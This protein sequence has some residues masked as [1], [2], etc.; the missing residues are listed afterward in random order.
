M[1]NKKKVLSSL[2]MLGSV[3][4]LTNCTKNLDQLPVSTATKDAIFG[5]E[6]GLKTYS[7]SFYDMLP[8]MG[9]IFRTDGNIS[10]YGATNQIPNYLTSNGYTADNATG[11]NWSD[12]R[13]VNYFIENCNYPT[14]SQSVREN[15]IGLARFFRAYFYYNKVKQ[16]GD[17]PWYSTSIGV[18]DSAAL[19]KKRD[20]RT[21]VMDSVVADLQYAAQHITTS[22][23]DTRSTVTQTVVLGYL[24]RIALYEG[25][26][27]KYHPEFKLQGSANAML[28]IAADAAQSIITSGTFRLNTGD[29]T[30]YRKLFTSDAPV[31]SEIML[32]NITSASL[33][34]YNDANWYF[35]SSTYGSRFSFIKKFMNTYL[36]IDGSSF[37]DK[38]GYDTIPYIRE[39]QN[40]DWRLQQTIRGTNYKVTTNGGNPTFAA[41][42]FSY[43]YTGYQPI[44]WVLDD[45]KYNNNSLNTNAISLLR[46]AEVLLNYAEAKAELGTLTATDWAQTIGALRSRAGIVNGISALPTQVDSYLQANY[47]PD[48][49]NPVILEIRR[50]RGIELALEGFRFDDLVRWKEGQNLTNTW[51]GMYVPNVGEIMDL[52]GDGKGDV[53]FYL[54]APTAKQPGVTYIDVSTASMALDHK[55]YG[56]LI[57]LGNTQKSWNDYKYLYPIPTTVL[58]K[59]S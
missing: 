31:A 11:W 19:F 30:S 9:D 20:P 40:R 33:S 36:N 12:L 16:F 4:G 13:N 54:T 55:T 8:G 1:F 25:S 24:S 44:K 22:A 18:S 52:N 46:Y 5:N 41:P 59:K 14:V 42:D 43:V 34:V 7:M 32:A 56:H 15:Y 6:S 10:D 28:Q 53:C 3:L 45:T 21:L 58:Q 2:V 29:N 39:V 17:V 38:A 48:I 37:T 50:E 23:E 47:F 51:E 49:N 35:T 27:R 26:F 57:W